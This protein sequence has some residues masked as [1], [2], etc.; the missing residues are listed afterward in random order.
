MASL[1]NVG[2]RVITTGGLQKLTPLETASGAALAIK[3]LKPRV[4]NEVIVPQLLEPAPQTELTEE[5]LATLGALPVLTRVNE[6]VNEESVEQEGGF[7]VIP[8]E[9]GQDG[10]FV[11][12][13]QP[14]GV[15]EAYSLMQAEGPDIPMFSE[16]PVPPVE[17]PV[18]Q[19][20][21]P[22]V[23]EGG[24]RPRSI[25]KRALPHSAITYP[26]PIPGMPATI[27]IPQ[28]PIITIDTG[29]DAMA[30]S[31]YASD[32]MGQPRRPRQPIGM[33][34]RMGGGEQAMGPPPPSTP[35]GAIFVN[36]LG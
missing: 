23:L 24:G 18:Q 25:L 16:Q 15:R 3:E 35:T 8:T 1:I 36:K 32:Y 28:G 29:F 26:A 21:Q 19:P 17:Q 11:M 33:I 6:V 20:M 10:G 13:Q 31:C 34:N 2:M 30:S 7:I 12:Q 9:I 5:Q 22:I 27:A 14:T 4:L